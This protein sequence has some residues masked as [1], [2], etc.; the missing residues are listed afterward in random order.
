MVRKLQAFKV[1]GLIMIYGRFSIR[2]FVVHCR[3][4]VTMIA[5]QKSGRAERTS[6][7]YSSYPC[8]MAKIPLDDVQMRGVR[9]LIG[10]KTSQDDGQ[11][12]VVSDSSFEHEKVV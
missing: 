9:R 4:L 5:T 3:L 12:I 10:G 7:S 11:Q 8:Q 6:A 2:K 1:I